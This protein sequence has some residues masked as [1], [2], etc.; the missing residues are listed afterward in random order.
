VSTVQLT[1]PQFI[2]KTEQALSK[3]L[4]LRVWMRHKTSPNGTI[5]YLAEQYTP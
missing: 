3:S 1:V 5:V 4:P 2:S